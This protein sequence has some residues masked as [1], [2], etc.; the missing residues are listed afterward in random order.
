MSN[1]IKNFNSDTKSKRVCHNFNINNINSTFFE[2]FL[3][4]DDFKIAK[5]I[6]HD[7]IHQERTAPQYGCTSIGW[8]PFFI[9]CWSLD[10]TNNDFF[11]KHILSEIR[12][13][14]DWTSNFQV[15]RIQASFKSEGMNG[16]WHFDDDLISAYTFCLYFNF[17]SVGSHPD[18]VE[19]FK[20]SLQTIN[21]DI[22]FF[23]LHT[24]KKNKNKECDDSKNYNIHQYLNNINCNDSGGYFMIKGENNPPRFIRTF[25]N[26][27][28]LFNS[29][30]FHT[31]NRPV[32]NNDHTNLRCVVAY[33]LYLPDYKN[34]NIPTSIKQPISQ[35]YSHDDILSNVQQRNNILDDI[36]LNQLK[37]II[38]NSNIKCQDVFY[39][40]SQYNIDFSSNEYVTNTI[41]N[42]IKNKFDYNGSLDYAFCKIQSKSDDESFDIISKDTNYTVFSLDINNTSIFKLDNNIIINLIKKEK[43]EKNNVEDDTEINEI[44]K[45][46][47][48]YNDPL[49]FKTG[50]M[51]KSHLGK[52]HFYRDFCLHKQNLL[53]SMGYLYF[54]SYDHP[55]LGI[56][57]EH[58]NNN[59][60]KFPSHYIH[61]T[62]PYFKFSGSRRISVIFVCKNI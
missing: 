16:Q 50:F 42:I 53:D 25:N 26:N 43:S 30:T 60:I 31:G 29:T 45:T 54:L 61:K 18:T 12:N 47:F 48:S 22:S 21:S 6:I 2:N 8:H 7:N 9:P 19:M 44:N 37:D 36:H 4:D 13:I 52:S 39:S 59:C 33:K 27:A 11:S 32:Y 15:K 62:S 1:F 23:T 46:E 17:T 3:T 40:S 28:A 10:L 14:D 56:A 35:F 57:Y 55:S 34:I 51:K 24:E 49:I 20:N 5:E 38:K 58:I 41:F